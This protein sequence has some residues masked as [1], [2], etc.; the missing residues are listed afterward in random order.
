MKLFRLV[1]VAVGMVPLI[2]STMHGVELSG[3]SKKTKAQQVRVDALFDSVNKLNT[4][5][6]KKLLKEVNANSVNGDGATPLESLILRFTSMSFSKAQISLFFQMVDLLIN[7][8][9]DVNYRNPKTGQSILVLAVYSKSAQLVEKLLQAGAWKTINETNR[10]GSTA[11]NILTQLPWGDNE[12]AI[13]RLLIDYGS[14]IS[15]NFYFPGQKQW[16]DDYAKEIYQAAQEGKKASGNPLV[17]IVADYLVG[18]KE[19]EVKTKKPENA[20]VD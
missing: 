10:A 15:V 8:Q 17:D 6:L 13:A 12:K 9:A 18:G 14:N 4:H 3:E 7:A 16:V 1:M 5:T 2:A 19:Q 11:F 20:L